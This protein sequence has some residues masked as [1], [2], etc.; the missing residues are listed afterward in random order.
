MAFDYFLKNV[1]REKLTEYTYCTV[2]VRRG[3]TP[4]LNHPRVW[5]ETLWE[6]KEV[7]P[8]P[9]LLGAGEI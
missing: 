3:L 1:D 5:A 6:P 8:P 7:A 9:G 4:L 2:G